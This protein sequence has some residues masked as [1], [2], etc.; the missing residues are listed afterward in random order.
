MT[1]KQRLFWSGCGTM[2][3]LVFVLVAAIVTL[4]VGGCST[5]GVGGEVAQVGGDVLDQGVGAVKNRQ[6]G[7]ATVTLVRANSPVLRGGDGKGGGTE[8]VTDDAGMAVMDSKNSL[9]VSGPDTN[10][11]ELDGKGVNQAGSGPAGHAAAVT[12]K[13]G[14]V[15]TFFS[16][17][18]MAATRRVVSKDGTEETLT[19]TSDPTAPTAAYGD[20]VL[21]PLVAYYTGLTQEKRA[22]FV[23]GV[24]ANSETTKAVV[25]KLAGPDAWAFLTALVSPVK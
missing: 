8:A 4:A 7:P 15:M 19:I 23:A 14:D 11:V 9:T 20:K 3:I 2:G 16:A 10:V 13:N 17:T 5:A 25:D 22:A 12:L 6:Q 21:G 1:M 18:A 24:Q